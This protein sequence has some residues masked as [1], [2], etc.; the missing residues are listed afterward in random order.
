M[1]LLSLTSYTQ[2]EIE[3]ARDSVGKA[4]FSSIMKEQFAGWFQRAAK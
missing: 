2:D 1:F 4:T 3:T